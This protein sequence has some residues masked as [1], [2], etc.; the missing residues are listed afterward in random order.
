V[1]SFAGKRCRKKSEYTF[2]VTNF[3]S[4]NRA[5][6]EIM[7]GGGDMVEADRPRTK[8]KTAHALGVMDN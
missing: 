2:Y 1:R 6:Y 3:R 5:V 8:V 7:G 4:E